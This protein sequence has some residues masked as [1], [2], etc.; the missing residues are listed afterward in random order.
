MARRD[1]TAAQQD[2]WE[3]DQQC[4]A[5]KLQSSNRDIEVLRALHKRIAAAYKKLQHMH[6]NKKR[7]DKKAI[8][9]MLKY[10]STIPGLQDE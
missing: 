9:Q 7:M 8:K 1:L 5:Q 6:A 10:L 4:R 3:A 2:L